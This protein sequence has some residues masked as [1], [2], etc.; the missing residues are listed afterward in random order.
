MGDDTR[1]VGVAEPAGGPRISPAAHSAIAVAFASRYYLMFE[2]W[3]V[4]RVL[5]KPR[6]WPYYRWRP[7][8]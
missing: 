7:G 1:G 4:R 5:N 6:S 2:W 3:A 8:M